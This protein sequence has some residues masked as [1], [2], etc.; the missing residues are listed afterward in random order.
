MAFGFCVRRRGPSEDHRDYCLAL[1]AR[2]ATLT[3]TVVLNH[4]RL[5]LPSCVF[6]S[7]QS[8]PILSRFPGVIS[9]TKAV[10]S[11]DDTVHIINRRSKVLSRWYLRVT[12]THF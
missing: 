9:L 10:P 6:P 4:I 8:F 7:S 3:R 12:I 11:S 1:L 2:Q 5:P